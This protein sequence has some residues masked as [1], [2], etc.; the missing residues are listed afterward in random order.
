MNNLI[1]FPIIRYL[2][3]LTV[4]ALAARILIP[5]AHLLGRRM[6]AWDAPDD[7]SH[8]THVFKLVRTGGIAIMGGIYVGRMVTLMIQPEVFATR[9]MAGVM[10]GGFAVFV[11]GLLD[12]LREIAPWLKAVLLLA[13]C[14]VT[15][16]LL[17]AVRLTG[18]ERLDFLLVALI[19]MGGANAFNLMDGLDGLAAGMA[20]AACLG[21]LALSLRLQLAEGGCIP[22]VII[23]TMLSFLYFN[24]PPARIF[25]GDCGSLLLGFHLAG[26]GLSVAASG[27]RA[28]I[29]VLLVF[30][31]FMLDTALAISRR[32]L[33][34]RDVFTGDRRHTYDM[35]HLRFLSAWRVDMVMWGMGV[36][37]AALGLIAVPLKPWWQAALLA[38]SWLAVVLWMVRLG[39]FRPAAKDGEKA[40]SY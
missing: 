16:M 15:A 11:V 34:R 28:F 6:N 14:L 23:G 2:L 20:I 24:L 12:D 27:P 7:L 17:N 30:S 19:L 37:F 36:A 29:P 26:M 10:L 31:P 22:M 39:M 8:D 13:A 35:L 9:N 1:A 25:M 32:L 4:S 40:G 21:L 5:L 33:S 18:F 3:V 38:G